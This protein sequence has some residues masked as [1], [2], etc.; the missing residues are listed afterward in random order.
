MHKIDEK[1]R[2]LRE[3]V[4]CIHTQYH[5][6]IRWLKFYFFLVRFNFLVHCRLN[7]L[8]CPSLF[9]RFFFNNFSMVQECFLRLWNVRVR[10]TENL[11][12]AK[13]FLS[14]THGVRGHKDSTK[15]IF[16][17]NICSLPCFKRSRRK[18]KKFLKHILLFPRWVTHFCY[19]S[20][21][22]SRS[23]WATLT[24]TPRN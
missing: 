7:Q 23:I 4:L 17:W 16:I 24:L 10:L 9:P 20:F 6:I 8:Y 14:P 1:N 21:F 12:L 18:A 19:L 22:V 13:R 3:R 2:V 11:V 5:V 15:R